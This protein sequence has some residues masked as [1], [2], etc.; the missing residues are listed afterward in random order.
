MH[1]EDHGDL[2]VLEAVELIDSLER[3]VIA[4]QRRPDDLTQLEEVFRVMHSFKGTAKM[5]GYPRIGELTHG[6]ETI[7]DDLRRGRIALTDDIFNI[8]HRSVHHIRHLLYRG[9]EDDNRHKAFMQEVRLLEAGVGSRRSVSPHSE[10]RLYLIRVVPGGNTWPSGHHPSTFISELS[11]FGP[12]VV[13]GFPDGLLWEEEVG[14]VTLLLYTP[15]GRQSICNEFV[16][17]EDCIEL[18]ISDLGAVNWIENSSVIEYFHAARG[19]VTAGM[20]RDFVARGK[21]QATSVSRAMSQATLV[22]SRKVD[23]IMRAVNELSE[24]HSRLKTLAAAGTDSSVSEAATAVG[25]LLRGLQDDT[26]GIS[27]LPVSLL[28]SRYATM[29][30]TT[31]NELGKKVRLI[32]ESN[33]VE[34]DAAIFKRLSEAL[35]HIIRNC[36]DHG[37]EL[38]GLRANRGKDKTGT[39]QLLSYYRESSLVIDVRDDGGGIDVARVRAKAIEQG[40][41]GQDDKLTADEVIALVFRA[42][43]TT[44]ERVSG[45]SGR[46]V[47]MDIVRHAITKLDGTLE[48]N[49][50]SGEGTHF[51]ICLPIAS[52]MISGMAV[53]V[54][55]QTFILPLTTVDRFS[56]VRRCT[57]V[58]G[59]EGTLGLDGVRYPFLSLHKL[60]GVDALEKE[61]VTLVVIRHPVRQVIVAVDAIVAERPFAIKP[62]FRTERR[63]LRMNQGAAVLDDGT[64]ALLLDTDRL[65][66]PCL[67]N[68]P[69][70]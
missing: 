69:D 18:K 57:V 61:E 33:G 3:A 46:G 68:T 51:R 17:V 50:K 54:G 4:L 27:L 30:D 32:A 52:G 65:L 23:R 59:S 25:Q 20:L 6:L 26:F 64:V 48:V 42:G 70:R 37:I 28:F 60:L 1:I 7:Y 8:T 14:E 22:D 62:I 34:L 24:V 45:V 31:A 47:G 66:F 10:A 67:S 36:I 40:F 12:L 21:A 41:I 35:M 58:P 19:E 15:A 9:D 11:S 29:V 5:F 43:L 63:E 2:F 56:E 55:H 38:P 13:K 39:I 53:A 44:A 16:E 49:S